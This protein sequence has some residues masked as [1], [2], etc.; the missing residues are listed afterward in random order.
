[1]E[2]YP[3]NRIGEIG[4]KCK[5]A[6]SY[7]TSHQQCIRKCYESSNHNFSNDVEKFRW[8]YHEHMQYGNTC[9]GIRNELPSTRTRNSTLELLVPGI[10]ALFTLVGILLPQKNK[11]EKRS[12]G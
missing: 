10:A 3:L 4:E 12:M 1:M 5:Y 8:I 2:R 7:V 11:K 6:N 9:S